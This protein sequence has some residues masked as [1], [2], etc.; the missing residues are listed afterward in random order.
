LH[1]PQLLIIEDD[2]VFAHALE[3][4]AHERGFKTLTVARGDEG[5]AL[6]KSQRPDA[7]T[8]DLNLPDGD[9]WNVAER[10]KSD[11]ETQ[12]I[13]VHVIS[14]RDRPASTEKYGIVSYAAKPVNIATLAQVFAQIM[15][16]T[17]RPRRALLVIENDSAKR[18]AIVSQLRGEDVELDAV[19]SAGEA[20]S[21]LQNR[22]Y[23]GMV[24]SLDLPDMNGE[25]LLQELRQ[26][27]KHTHLP[28]VMYSERHLGRNTEDQFKKLGATVLT[29]GS[30]SL[31]L[32]MLQ[33]AQFLH[34]VASALPES[35][36]A[37]LEQ[38]SPSS[39]L[40]KGKKVLIVDDDMRNL[41]A[42]TG[43]LEHQGMAVFTAENGK[44]AIEKL[45]ETQDIDIVLMDIMMP[46]M[47]GYETMQKIR[48][49]AK[50]KDLPIIAL[51][52]K[53]MAGDR[54]KC[55]AAGASDYASKPIDTE[56]LLSQLR[57]WLYK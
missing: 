28:V 11:P 36:R 15:Q 27:P 12:D 6:A 19:S 17:Q 47:D 42:L 32:L 46:D 57:V 13:P 30:R 48:S 45:N 38:L 8:L 39:K 18:E 52:V 20:R 1:F 35:K 14:V 5:L 49:D 21:A 44:D 54:E 29:E 10:L 26:D 23:Q 25:A 24:L 2:P 22:S 55:L 51:T 34:R 4:M 31:D 41:F 56:Q 7:I 53:A 16:E 37:M 33:T 40:L 43:L 9:G 50:F 3:E